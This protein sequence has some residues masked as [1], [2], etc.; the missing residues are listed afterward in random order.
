MQYCVLFGDSTNI[1]K[2]YHF[3]KIQPAVRPQYTTVYLY[4]N[5]YCKF[6]GSS[7]A[8]TKVSFEMQRYGSTTKLPKKKPLVK[9]IFLAIAGF[10][11][12]F[13]RLLFPSRL[14][15]ERVRLPIRNL[16][17]LLRNEMNSH[18]II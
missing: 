17:T 15:I 14:K 13:L 16:G 10:I 11:A 18:S 5:I 4:Y 3:F 1:N 6:S 12:L 8:Q 2:K 7:T 9:R